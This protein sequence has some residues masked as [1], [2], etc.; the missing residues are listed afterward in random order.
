PPSC[1]AI[2]LIGIPS[3]KCSRR[4]SAQSSTC[5]IPFV[6]LARW[7]PESVEGVRFQA[8]PQGQL[9]RV[10]D[11]IDVHLDRQVCSIDRASTRTRFLA[12]LAEDLVRLWAL[13]CGPV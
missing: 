7:E 13:M 12:Q 6:L 9:S 5:N 1:R 3:A 10:A 11:I 2:C 8:K 4:I